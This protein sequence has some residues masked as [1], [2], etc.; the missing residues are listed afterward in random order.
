VDA[1]R[2]FAQNVR[3]F[4]SYLVRNGEL[5]TDVSDEIIGQSL[6]TTEGR[7]VHRGTLLA[8]GEETK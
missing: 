2:M 3:Y 1:T 5:S 6:V 7:I 4:L 8:M